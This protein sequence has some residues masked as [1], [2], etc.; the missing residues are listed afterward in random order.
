MPL[1]IAAKGDLKGFTLAGSLGETAQFN[2]QWLL[3]GD[4]L[5][6]ARAIWQQGTQTSP[7]LPEQS[8]LVLALPA[9]DAE[10]WLGLLPALRGDTVLRKGAQSNL[11]VPES[12]TLR[13]PALQLLGQ[14]WHDVVLNN[15]NTPQGNEI[16]T[17]GREIDA[18]L[19]VPQSGMWRADIRYLYYNPQWKGDEA[20]N[21][22]ALA[23][24]KSPLDDPSIRF[25]DWPAL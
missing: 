4:V 9:L 21:T 8:E 3:R 1:K 18:N 12:V 23:E 11:H 14:Q 15:R 5:T 22:V 17:T 16:Y 20:T 10:R 25:E 13:T 2:S 19:T 7:T 24:K 6:L